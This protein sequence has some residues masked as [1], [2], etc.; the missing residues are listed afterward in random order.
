MSILKATEASYSLQIPVAIIGAGGCGLTA[1]LAAAEAGASPLVLEADEQALGTTSMSTGLIPAAGSRLQKAAGIEDSAEL[2]AEDILAKSKHQ[3]DAEMVLHLARESAYTID[4]LVERHGVELSLVDSF[5]YPGHSVKRMHGS[6]NRSGSELMAG[7]FNAVEKAGVDVLTSARVESL[8]QRDDGRIDGIRCRRPDNSTE[9]LACDALILACCGFAGNP[10]MV[11]EYIPEI[12]K[13]EFFGHPGNKGDAI[14]WGRALGAAIDDI[15]S[16]QGHGGLA[17][18][19]GVPILWPLIMEGGFQV[20]QLGERFS[21]EARGY[22][23]Q[24]VDVVAQPDHVAWMVYDQRLHDMM[25]EFDDYRDAMAQK[26][27]RS[28]T[29]I[30]GLAEAT[31]MPAA[32]L[33]TTFKEVAGAIRGETE[34][35]FGRQFADRPMLASPYYAVKVTGALFHTQ[36]GLRVD[37]EA[38]VVRQDGSVLPNLYAGGGAARG[39]SGPGCS[40]YLAGN[41]LLTATTLGRLAGESAARRHSGR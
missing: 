27:I 8:F 20:N 7:L 12:A 34:D 35:P 6:L 15:H 22:S 41:G 11:A 2:F 23:E 38:R 17:V 26:A 24:A 28:A 25:Q 39:V 37:R 40:G 10:Q 3:T 21:N 18:G 4:W 36:G 29:D 14:D 13:A 16:Y 9:D 30:E 1:A 31:K 5:R 32:S 33:E 19:Q